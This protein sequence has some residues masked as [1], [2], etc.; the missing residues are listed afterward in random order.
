MVVSM[1]NQN[2]PWSSNGFSTVF[3]RQQLS[4]FCRDLTEDPEYRERLR[5]EFIA[6]TLDRGM[7]QMIWFYAYGKPQENIAVATFPGDDLS[8]LSTTDLKAKAQGALDAL[9]EA[10][11][12]ERTLDV[13]KVA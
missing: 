3:T 7:E 8:A 13:E 5:K 1:K 9:R 10:E 12:I 6:R 11:E 2:L 4:K